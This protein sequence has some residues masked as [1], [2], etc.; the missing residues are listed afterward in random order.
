MA[1]PLGG[2]LTVGPADSALGWDGVFLWRRARV[3]PS[4]LG[5]SMLSDGEEFPVAG[6]SPQSTWSI[7]E[8]A[9][10]HHDDENSGPEFLFRKRNVRND[11]V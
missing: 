1:Q 11:G 10:S 4:C 7:A 3:G 6:M 2:H 8:E 9:G 5:M